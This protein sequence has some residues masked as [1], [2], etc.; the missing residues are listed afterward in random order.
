MPGRRCTWRACTISGDGVSRDLP[1]ACALYEQ[2]VRTT[3]AELGDSNA[4]AKFR[5]VIGADPCLLAGGS[6]SPEV[7]PSSFQDYEGGI[8]DARRHR[9]GR[10]FRYSSST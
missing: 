1:L 4:R 7:G 10:P 6:E 5:R 3:E 2:A 8:S 9:H